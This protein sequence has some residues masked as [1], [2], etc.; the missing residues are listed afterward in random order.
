M[1]SSPTARAKLR[2]GMEDFSRQLRRIMRSRRLTITQVGIGIG[3]GRGFLENWLVGKRTP[4]DPGYCDWVLVTLRELPIKKYGI[5]G[6]IKR[7]CCETPIHW[8]VGI[9]RL[10]KYRTTDSHTLFGGMRY[11]GFKKHDDGI[12]F[13]FY[14]IG[15]YW[16]QLYLTDRGAREY[17]FTFGW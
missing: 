2:K 3:V 6:Y 8:S 1:G 4:L 7:R 17:S 11:L 10:I 14:A 12:Y 9:D 16:F 13:R 15:F 5:W